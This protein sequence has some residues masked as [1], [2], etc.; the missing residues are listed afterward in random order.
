MPQTRPRILCADD[1]ADIREMLAVLLYSAGYDV[2]SAATAR[3]AELLAAALRFDLFILDRMP[4]RGGGLELCRELR[5]R[6]PHTP[7]I[8]YSA[9]ASAHH[10]REAARAGAAACV[11]KPHV[12]PLVSAVKELLR[13]RS[14]TPDLRQFGFNQPT[15]A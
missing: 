12:S 9:D 4:P 11:D 10:H 1:N 5:R 7:V 2:T 13:G 6:H 3:E 14:V 8:I 15:L